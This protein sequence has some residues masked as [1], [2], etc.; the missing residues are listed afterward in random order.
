MLCEVVHPAMTALRSGL[1]EFAATAVASLLKPMTQDNRPPR[2]QEEIDHGVVVE[3][4]SV[5]APMA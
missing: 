2:C 3:R 1:F 4:A 5:A